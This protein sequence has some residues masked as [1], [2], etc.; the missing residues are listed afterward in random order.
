MSW[1]LSPSEGR[2]Y[3]K[4]IGLAIAAVIG[5]ILFFWIIFGVYRQVGAG[6]VGVVTRQGDVVRT[7]ESGPVWKLPWENVNKLNVQTQKKEVI[8]ESASKDLQDVKAKLAL[9][10]NLKRDSALK[11]FKD[12]GKDYEARIVDPALQEVFK[13]TSAEF[14]AAEL[15]TKRD[16]VKDQAQARLVDR[17]EDQ[18]IHVS[19]LSIVNFSFSPEF[20]QA[21]EARQVAEQAALT[22]D[23]NL[24]KAKLDAQTQATLSQTLSEQI[25]AKQF[26]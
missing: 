11:V 22:A 13:A 23:A 9:N 15:I 2:S 21:L 1:S 25:L 4:I 19:G 12:I 24:R 17:L 8:A 20:T 16:E 26:L 14:T 3:G 6:Q 18:G 10:Y 5:V 7:V